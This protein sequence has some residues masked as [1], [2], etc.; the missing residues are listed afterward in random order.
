MYDVFLHLSLYLTLFL[1]KQMWIANI[2]A[3][4]HSFPW[5]VLLDSSGD[6]AWSHLLGSLSSHRCSGNYRVTLGLYHPLSGPDAFCLVLEVIQ[7]QREKYHLSPYGRGNNIKWKICLCYSLGRKDLEV[8]C[9]PW[10]QRAVSS[11]C[12]LR[13]GQAGEGASS[14]WN[15]CIGKCLHPPW[16]R[17]AWFPVCGTAGRQQTF[18]AHGFNSLGSGICL[19]QK[20]RGHLASAWIYSVLA[21]FLCT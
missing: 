16:V 4:I 20:V 2:I 13:C 10:V 6:R 18:G 17:A 5:L 8:A 3:V 7:G 21:A 15:C 12:R 11:G 19:Y 9:L 1:K 14:A